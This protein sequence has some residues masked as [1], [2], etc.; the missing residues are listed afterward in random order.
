MFNRKLN[1]EIYR[2]NEEKKYRDIS[3][4]IQTKYSKDEPVKK[5][6]ALADQPSKYELMILAD[7]VQD[8]LNIDRESVSLSS[9]QLDYIY[10]VIIDLLTHLQKDLPSGVYDYSLATIRGVSEYILEEVTRNTQNKQKIKDLNQPITYE[11]IFMF[12]SKV[13][14]M[15]SEDLFKLTADLLQSG[16]DTIELLSLGLMGSNLYTRQWIVN[17]IARETRGLPNALF[18][19]DVKYIR[20][21]IPEILVFWRNIDGLLESDSSH[22]LQYI[23]KFRK[24]HSSFFNS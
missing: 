6:K 4:D 24:N 17:R 13:G 3:F 19:K 15:S 5:L 1:P 9:G 12:E 10:R 11:E 2:H 7:V 18:Q 23:H 22:Q 16:L 14:K 21:T 20:D 8:Y